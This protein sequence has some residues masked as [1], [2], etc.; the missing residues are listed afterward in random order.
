LLLLLL[1]L[2][3]LMF[4]GGHGDV[5][6]AKLANFTEKLEKCLRAFASIGR[7]VIACAATCKRSIFFICFHRFTNLFVSIVFWSHSPATIWNK[8]FFSHIVLSH[9][10]L[11]FS[12]LISSTL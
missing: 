2:P 7:L 12:S 8:F 1:L 5:P 3:P 11:Y 10:A 4:C 6:S 9:D